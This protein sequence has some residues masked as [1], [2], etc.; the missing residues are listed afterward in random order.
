MELKD[1]VAIVTG[2]ARG[3]GRE[4]ALKLAGAGADVA[5][6]DIKKEL[7]G[8][9]V[10]LAEELGRK[11]VAYGCNVADADEVNSTVKAILGDFEK[12]D[13]LVNNAGITRD[14]LLMRMTDEEWDAVL[15][16]NL[17]GVFNFTRTVARPMMKRRSG[18]IVNIASVVGITGN[19]GQANYSAS[20]G[21]VI[22]LT[23]TTAQELAPR[24]INVNAVAPGFI[25]TQM[26]DAL[27]ENV[28][29]DILTRIPFGKM[30]KPS[31]VAGVVLFL[32]GPLSDYVTG[33]T[34]VVAGGM[35]M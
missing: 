14:N 19:A 27:P 29:S 4:I 10:A 12:I 32:C 24:G 23:K 11:A 8:E 18:R 34:V 9:T 31:D 20:K 28:K 13:I 16:V 5:V 7:G 15:G 21:G 1:K 35:V 3:I 26:T 2:A 33:H 22:T 17:K 6:V 30:G 25:E